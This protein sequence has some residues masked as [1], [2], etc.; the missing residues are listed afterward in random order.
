MEK[1]FPFVVFLE[2]SAI[3][4]NQLNAYVNDSV[5][6]ELG[7]ECSP[8]DNASKRILIASR[9]TRNDSRGIQL[10]PR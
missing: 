9:H 2:K 5:S 1:M 4:N 7:T 8:Y 10:E 3:D 6:D